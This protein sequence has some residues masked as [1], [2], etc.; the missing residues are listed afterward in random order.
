M[1]V[2]FKIY[3]FE[4]EKELQER[5]DI[6]ELEVSDDE[7]ILDILNK[8]KWTKDGSLSYRRSCRH[9][10]CGSCAVKLNGKSILAC[11]T[12]IKKAV[13]EFGN[14]L[15]IEPLDK[16][17]VIKDLIIDKSDFW[18][19]FSKIKPYLIDEI[20]ENPKSENIIPP[21]I[22]E[23]I[24]NADYCISCGCCFY[25]C[26]SY[27]VNK[28]FLGPQA[29]A[30]TYRFTADVRDKAKKERLE[31][32]NELGSGVWDCV[33]CQECSEV[34]PKDVD[35]FAK[36]THLHNQ[37][38]DEGVAKKNV[39]TKHAEGFVHSIKKHG[40]LDKGML[41]LYSEGIKVLRYLPKAVVMF[42]KG[43]IKL[44]WQMPQSK[45]LHEI[46]KLI[47]ISQTDKLKD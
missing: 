20:D 19:K 11:K 32:V 41:V 39:A 15:V 5:Y 16:S 17:R 18:N 35:P 22:A 30:K 14:V 24:E 1:L 29:L 38:F 6:Y 2:S 36:I 26:E 43:K 7:V 8:I 44:P 4:P 3:R 33:K 9:G 13:E 27:R 37:I 21:K 10:I 28:S 42:K 12:S 34:C 40:I 47:E 45:G 46:Q 23:M 25:A 31:I